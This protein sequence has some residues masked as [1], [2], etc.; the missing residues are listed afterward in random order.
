MR[1]QMLMKTMMK[2]AEEGG[3]DDDDDAK[4]AKGE[5]SELKIRIDKLT[6][7]ACYTIFAYVRQALFEE[8][9]IIFATQLCMRILAQRGQLDSVLFNFLMRGPR[10]MSHDNPEATREWLS[11]TN[12]G[13]IQSL[14]QN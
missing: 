14:K 4:P 11:D 6:E 3:N 8:H 5:K 2:M 1:L 12:W 7:V 10:D 13:A 9:K